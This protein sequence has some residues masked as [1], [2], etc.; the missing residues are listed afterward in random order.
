MLQA[1]YGDRIIVLP[2]VDIGIGYVPEWGQYLINTIKFNVGEEPDFAIVGS[3]LR[4][5]LI[6]K[7]KKLL[8]N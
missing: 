4:L 3:E 5:K 8:F 6:I 7:F 1:I 2:I